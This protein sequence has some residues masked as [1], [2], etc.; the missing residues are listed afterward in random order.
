MR[1]TFTSLKDQVMYFSFSYQE[2][3]MYSNIEPY[4]QGHI[5]V[6][7]VH[8]LY[9]EE[10]GNPNGQPVVFFHG[11]PGGNTSP[12][13]RKLFHPQKFRT[14]LFDQ[15]GCGKSIPYASLENNTTHDLV[16]DIE[17]IRTYLQIENWMIMFSLK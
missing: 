7:D 14:I 16:E 11:G 8:S 15:R 4:N 12:F 5:R 1:L 17:K 13:Y 10:C 2:R 9:F 6:S 3:R